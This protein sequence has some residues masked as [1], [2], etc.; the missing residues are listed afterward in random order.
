MPAEDAPKKRPRLSFSRKH[1]QAGVVAELLVL[2]EATTSDG[3]ISEAEARG[4]A[5]WL[6]ENGPDSQ[7]PGIAHLREKISEILA[8]GRVN[9]RGMRGFIPNG[10]NYPS[11]NHSSTCRALPNSAIFEKTNSIACWTRRSE[12]GRAHV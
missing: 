4:L 3:R 1:T 2:L 8:D 11:R 7:I 9:A 10:R 12:I 5:E 6:N